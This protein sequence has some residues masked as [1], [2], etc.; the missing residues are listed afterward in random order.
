M[1]D[2]AK[3]SCEK[4][5]SENCMKMMEEMRG[6]CAGSGKN[7]SGN[8]DRFQE[9]MKMGEKMFRECKEKWCKD[10]SDNNKETGA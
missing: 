8:A 9:F 2:T 7:D 3:S 4:M 5:F 10:A 6:C 1:G